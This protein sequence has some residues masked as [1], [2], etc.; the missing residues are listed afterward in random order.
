M[1]KVVPTLVALITMSECIQTYAQT[2]SF[3]PTDTIQYDV[4]EA[5]IGMG[6]LLQ[7]NTTDSITIEAVRVIDAKTTSGGT[8]WITHFCLSVCFPPSVDSVRVKIPPAG[9]Y[10]ILDIETNLTPDSQTVYMRFKDVTNPTYE[11][12]QRFH[13]ITVL[14]NGVIGSSPKQADIKI[15]PSPAFSDDIINID[16]SNL[17]V[18]D[19]N[20]TLLA[21]SIYGNKV[22]ELGG[23]KNGSNSF[24][25]NLPAGIYSYFLHS[26]NNE[27]IGYNNISVIK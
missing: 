22:L 23:L 4:P 26:S 16:I 19:N 1:K 10:F 13:T 12:Y 15:Y 11:V 6:N 25:L 5:F 14:G 3:I 24:R 21:Y 2:F 17:K 20:I 8:D 18:I 7:N 9:E 27:V